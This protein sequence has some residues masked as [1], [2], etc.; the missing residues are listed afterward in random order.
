MKKKE[1][2]NVIGSKWWKG[3]FRWGAQGRL[4]RSGD[5]SET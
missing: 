5:V 2:S 4:L 3:R 1:K